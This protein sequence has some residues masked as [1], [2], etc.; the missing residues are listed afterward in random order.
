MRTILMHSIIPTDGTTVTVWNIW[1]PT[2]SGGGPN[3]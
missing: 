2:P 1:T 3:S